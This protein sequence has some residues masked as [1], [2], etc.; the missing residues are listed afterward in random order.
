[1][2][3]ISFCAILIITLIFV[4]NSVAQIE[5]VPNITLKLDATT[6]IFVNTLGVSADF[7]AVKID[8]TAFFG[9]RIGLNTFNK[10]TVGGPV[11]GSPF[12]DIDFLGRITIY[13][14]VVEVSL[15]PGFTYH[16][17]DY[18]F[19]PLYGEEKEGLFGKFEGDVKIKF[20]KSIVGLIAK[21]G[22]SKE[23]YGGLG[24][25]VGFS[26]RDK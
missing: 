2:R 23:G 7:D 22:L 9:C 18:K 21:V 6:A 26:T 11:T 4:K 25:F 20:Y 19:F 15:S 17:G 3:I 1:M 16:K 13:G 14:K 24:L 5:A 10:G 12:T 8:S